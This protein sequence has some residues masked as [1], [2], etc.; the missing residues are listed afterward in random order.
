MSPDSL[1]LKIGIVGCGRI[2]TV[3]AE[4][5]QYDPRANVVAVFDVD[6]NSV[7]TLQQ[8]VAP[9]ATC[10]SSFEEML[11]SAPM[12]GVIIATPTT[13]H[14]EQVMQ[15]YQ[16]GLSILCEKP[17]AESRSKICDLIKLKE[18]PNQ[19]LLLGYQRRYWETWIQLKTE[20]ES[21]KWGELLSITS[22]NVEDW[23]STIQGTWRDDPAI[24]PLGF[25]GDVGSHKFDA[26][27]F[28]TKVSPQEVFA[29]SWNCGSQ[30]PIVTMV[31]AIMTDQNSQRDIP[32]HLDLIGNANRLS[33]DV[34]LHC[35]HADLMI[36][37]MTE[38]WIAENNNWNLMTYEEERAHPTRGF[39]D[40][41]ENPQQNSPSPFSAALLVHDFTTAILQS[42]QQK[43]PI[44]L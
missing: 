25:L 11:N 14:Y 23:Q 34:H 29:R 30:V 24:N 2:G 42:I 35:E 26:I 13:S 8:Q 1:P 37:N 44:V 6:T 38:F 12:D 41:L 9:T 16:H 36:R 22:H 32:L 15:S 4:R 19:K 21:G 43:N 18:T 7:Q 27:F 10:Y 17:L 3:H 5:I 28:A 33:E 40:L 31:S 39:L 20:L